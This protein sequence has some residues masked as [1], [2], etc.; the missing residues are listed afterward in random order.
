MLK[1]LDFMETTVATQAPKDTT[2]IV[3]SK[4][5][6]PLGSMVKARAPLAHRGADDSDS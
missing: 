3:I 2:E 1:A 6:V 5:L 4:P